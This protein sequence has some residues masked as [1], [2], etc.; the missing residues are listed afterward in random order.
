MAVATVTNSWDR[1]QLNTAEA[2]ESN[3]FKKQTVVP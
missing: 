2:Q 1:A 3:M